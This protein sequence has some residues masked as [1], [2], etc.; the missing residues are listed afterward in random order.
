MKKAILRAF[1]T[2]TMTKT[3][4]GILRQPT[5]YLNYFF[6][7]SAR[8]PSPSQDHDSP[9]RMTSSHNVDAEKSPTLTSIM[10]PSQ[11]VSPGRKNHLSTKNGNFIFTIFVGKHFFRLFQGSPLKP[12]FRCLF[13]NNTLG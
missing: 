4:E 8:L 2:K 6:F 3:I 7:R 13:Y 1:K 11:Q 9:E 5:I 10:K 12:F